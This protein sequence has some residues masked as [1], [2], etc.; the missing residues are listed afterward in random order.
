MEKE[1]EVCEVGFN[2]E[3]SVVV[4]PDVHCR[5]KGTGMKE[6]THNSYE[7]K[8]YIFIFCE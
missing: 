5:A 8:K 1:A 7:F 3:M 2:A 6:C 4:L